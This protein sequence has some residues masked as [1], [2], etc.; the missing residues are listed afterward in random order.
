MHLLQTVKCMHAR[1]C[2]QCCTRFG[3]S[4]QLIATHFSYDVVPI[5]GAVRRGNSDSFMRFAYIIIRLKSYL[6]TA[7][8]FKPSNAAITHFTHDGRN[9]AT[10]SRRSS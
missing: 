2:T 5:W 9:I 1:H 7:L 8:L 10:E 4:F 3:L 6:L